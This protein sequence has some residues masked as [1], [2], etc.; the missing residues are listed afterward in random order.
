[1]PYHG[2]LEI[3]CGQSACFQCINNVLHHQARGDHFTQVVRG[4]RISCASSVASGG[5]VQRSASESS[6]LAPSDTRTTQVLA[7]QALLYTIEGKLLS[8]CVP[9]YRRGHQLS[10][11]LQAIG[12]INVTG[13]P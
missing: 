3:R 5:R 6:Q 1:M 9:V 2:G 12:S 7:V 11:C 10:A 4:K 13:A 8:S